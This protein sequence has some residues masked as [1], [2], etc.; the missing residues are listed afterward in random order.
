MKDPAEFAQPIAKK[1]MLEGYLAGSDDEHF[2]IDQERLLTLH[3]EAYGMLR[4]YE[5]RADRA[6]LMPLDLG[7]RSPF[8]FDD[9]K[10]VGELTEY[11]AVNSPRHLG[12]R[13]INALCMS[14]QNVTLLP[15]RD[16]LKDVVLHVPVF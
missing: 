15:H 5:V 11:S 14:F 13:A 3:A 1:M 10:F 4:D 7:D 12:R 8:I 2:D 9:L 16:A 6:L